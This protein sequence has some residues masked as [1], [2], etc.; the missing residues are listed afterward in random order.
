MVLA[1]HTYPAPRQHARLLTVLAQQLLEN[2]SLTFAQVNAV[3]VGLGPGSFTGLR[4]A[5]SAAKGYAMALGIPVVGV[6][7]PQGYAQQAALWAP[8]LGCTQVLSLIDARRM[9]V[10]AGA[11]ALTTLG[12]VQPIWPTPKAEVLTPSSFSELFA[13][14]RTLIIG[15]GAPKSLPLWAGL[16]AV[17][18]LPHLVCSAV[19]IGL[20]AAY[21]LTELKQPL[22][23]HTTLEELAQLEPFYLKPVNI[24]P[25][26]TP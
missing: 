16:P 22:L 21:R 26:K 24:T 13:Q 9:E 25:P 1:E 5:L 11:Y 12:P 19:G 15:D 3:A 17:V 18:G 14:G 2:L 4:I 10:F 6:H 8:A 23:A 7:T 20:V